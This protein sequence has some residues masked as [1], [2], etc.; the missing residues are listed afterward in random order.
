MLPPVWTPPETLGTVGAVTVTE[1]PVDPDVEAVPEVEP[2]VLGVVAEPLTPPEIEGTVGVV[3]EPLTL[4]EAEGTV[5]VVAEPLPLPEVE[6]EAVALGVATTDCKILDFLLNL[7]LVAGVVLVGGVVVGAGVVTP[8][9]LVPSFMFSIIKPT[10]LGSLETDHIRAENCL[11]QVFHS[12]FLAVIEAS[13]QQVLVK[14]LQIDLLSYFAGAWEINPKLVACGHVPVI[15]AVALDPDEEELLEVEA[16]PD[17]PAPMCNPTD[18]ETEGKVGVVTATD[19]VVTATVGAA[20]VAEAP[21]DPLAVP[22]VEPVVVG[23]VAE[24]LTLPET[25]GTVGVVADAPTDPEAVA[26]GVVT[27]DWDRT[28]FVSNIKDMNRIKTFIFYLDICFYN[29]NL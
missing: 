28:L 1:P 3:T 14:L 22:D 13:V 16:D 11:F 23:V 24:P 8:Q 2:V 17:A 26:L 25:D 4:P 5:G 10:I 29:Q 7:L 21:V 27:I 6:V 12:V 15:T 9:S 20:T 19:G 18:P